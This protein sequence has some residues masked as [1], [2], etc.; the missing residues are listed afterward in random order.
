M[1]N[2][3]FQFWDLRP[4]RCV[5][6]KALQSRH[7]RFKAQFVCTP[8]GA[9]KQGGLAPALLAQ[10]VSWTRYASDHSRRSVSS[11]FFASSLPTAI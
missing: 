5:R 1:G 4:E 8:C 2:G 11:V 6:F 7:R 10:T 9:L 3:G